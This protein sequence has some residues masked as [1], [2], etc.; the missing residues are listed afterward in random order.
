MTKQ[1]EHIEH[2]GVVVKVFDQ[3]VEV[4]VM[5]QSACSAC[6]AKGACSMADMEEKQVNALKTPGSSYTEGQQVTVYMRKNLG[7]LAV[8][9]G[10]IIPFLLVIIML[11]GLVSLGFGQGKAGLI[12]L[13]TLVPYY[14]VLYLNRNRLN[15]TFVFY[16]K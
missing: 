9:Y 15:S 7:N 1:A 11:F 4:K 2:P 3:Y 13:A 6:H 5:S 16:A 8:F 10:Y 14:I 12:A